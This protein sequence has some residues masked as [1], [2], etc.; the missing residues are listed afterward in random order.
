MYI[1]VHKYEQCVGVKYGGNSPEISLMNSC[2]HHY[3]LPPK[4]W[5]ILFSLESHINI[6]TYTIAYYYFVWNVSCIR[7]N[8]LQGFC[9]VNENAANDFVFWVWHTLTWVLSCV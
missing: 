1:I 3:Y 5:D 6:Y 7:T 2:D 9:V 4:S 8:I